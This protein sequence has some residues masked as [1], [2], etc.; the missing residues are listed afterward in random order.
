[1]AQTT[2]PEDRARVLERL[3]GLKMACSL[4]AYVRGATERFYAWLETSHASDD[5]PAGPAVWICG[6]CHVGNLGP[7]AGP[8]GEVE[9][10][11]R[12]LD[13]TVIGNPAHD[14]IRL[15]LSLG[16]AARVSDLPGVTTAKMI[17]AMMEGYEAALHEPGDGD[18][19]PEP[20]GVATVH[21]LALGRR[22]RKLARER[23]GAVEPR[24][25][26]GK[27]FWPL[28]A[29]EREALEALVADPE[30]RRRVLAAPDGARATL[31]DAAYWRKGCSSL[32]KLRFAG[33]VEIEQEKGPRWMLV[34]V[35]E[36][37]AA[38]APAALDADM[39][40]D[41]AD[42]VVAGARALSPELGERM[43]AG[44]IGDR[45]VFAR[46]LKPQD[47]KLEFE[48]FSRAEATRSARYLAWVVGRAHAGQMDAHTRDRWRAE[49]ARSRPGALQPPSWLW[50]GVVE[51]AANHEA[52]YLE[53]CRIYAL[54]TAA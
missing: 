53:H 1:M 42:R 12:D 50:T 46:E 36:A 28:A 51:L 23:L 25:P 24:I 48:Q 38:A 44:R 40:A 13:Q 43:A 49:L 20:A 31:V 21:Q 30:V 16:T 29:G 26:I 47:L 10:R 35:K 6:D 18:A 37:G 52:G 22:W 8:D 39:P 11:I 41:P 45:P 34:D 27:R 19:V 33:V 4:H 3:R 2:A 7:L 32:G 14:L 54:E 5:L 9:V 15:G 17:E